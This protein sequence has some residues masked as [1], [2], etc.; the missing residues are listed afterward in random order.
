M[1]IELI[2]AIAR[3]VMEE[4]RS[5][6]EREPGWL[7]YHGRRTARLSQWLAKELS[8]RVDPDV[9]YTGALFHDVG[10]G[11]E[12]HNQVGAQRARELLEAH[13]TP[14]ELDA[15]CDVIERHNRR[16]DASAPL[17][18][19][20]VQDADLLDHVG[21]IGVWTTIYANGVNAVRFEDHQ[22]A[23]LSE[24]RMTARQNLRR[25]LNFGVA[26]KLFD[27][28]VAEERA[29]FDRFHRVYVHGDG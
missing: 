21:I 23:H 19:R 2:E 26:K 22:R 1:D 11:S 15:I 13:C 28:R 24:Q 18:A 16:R 3:E 29:F 20:I 25:D 27:L 9:V 10:L 4:Q 17:A 8:A 6:L 14:Q 5:K 12:P 7:Y